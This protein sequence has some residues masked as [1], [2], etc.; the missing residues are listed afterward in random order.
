[1]KAAFQKGSRAFTLAETLIAAAVSSIVLA[2][3]A[4]GAV[5]LRRTYESAAYHMLAQTEQLRVFDYVGRDLRGASGAT[6]LDAGTRLDLTIPTSNAGSL[7]LHLALPLGPLNPAGPA[8]RSV[9]YLLEGDR[10]LRTENGLP[11]EVARTVTDFRVTRTG[12]TMEVTATFSPRY[13][14]S[15]IAVVQEAMRLRSTFLLRNQG[16]S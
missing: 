13:C 3:I 9:S 7:A 5:A 16:P 2:A 8:N 6:V 12:S 1:M 10:L 14:R 11:K 15:P 4:A